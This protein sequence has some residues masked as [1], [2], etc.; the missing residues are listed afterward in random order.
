MAAQ[1]Q[2]LDTKRGSVLWHFNQFRSDLLVALM[3]DLVEHQE[4]GLDEDDCDQVLKGLAKMV[5]WAS[6]FPD[7]SFL[8]R[9]V[10]QEMQEFEKSFQNWCAI[11]GDRSAKQRE[12]QKVLQQMRKFRNRL[13]RKARQNQFILD[14]EL[15]LK[16]IDSLYDIL[17]GISQ[18]V[19]NFFTALTK[20]LEKIG[21]RKS[22]D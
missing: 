16:L 22:Q 14:Q 4:T 3:D 11:K 17:H 12:R 19:P 13:S 9:S 8:R 6:A 21:K 18:S 5:N 2:E 1:K 7:G 10:Y 15:D 20:A